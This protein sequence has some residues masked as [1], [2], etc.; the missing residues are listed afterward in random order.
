MTG[1][2]E[3]GGIDRVARE[4][5]AE[6]LAAA[7]VTA[8]ERA[9]ARLA[10]LLTDAIVA[11]ALE[12]RDD[13]A[14][15]SRDDVAPP[16]PARVPAPARALYAYAVAWGD[17]RYPS[18]GPALT[19][20][21][22]IDVVREDDLGLLVSPVAP[23]ELEVDP[24]DLSETGRLAL[25][26]RGH[27]AVV[28]AAA[29]AGPVLPLRFGTV[30]PD[31]EAARRLLRSHAG[32]AR[33]QLQRIGTAREW[34]VRL[35]RTLTAGA[36]PA[37][38]GGGQREGLSGTEYLSRRREALQREDDLTRTAGE[39]AERLQDGLAGHVT[40]SLRRGGSPGSSLLLDMAYLVPIDEEA[41][42]LGEVQH[43][44]EDLESRGLALEV[45]GPWPPYSFVALTPGGSDGP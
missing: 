36:E 34:G 22:P 21:R 35:V 28:R 14:L 24:D 41:G 25:L 45:T 30:V 8:R 27:D 19:T 10:D 42:F 37:L 5:A 18:D 6:V 20:G 11:R 1:Q 7:L 17:L 44:T 4:V 15:E 23:D 26:A 9:Q 33:D 13:D 29:D 43:L 32:S 40:E 39:C 3:S 12:T 31:E 16:P 38:A 2:G